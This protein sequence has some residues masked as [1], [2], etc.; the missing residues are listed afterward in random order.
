MTADIGII[1]S[2]LLYLLPSLRERRRYLLFEL[3]GEREIDK[4]EL[5][6]EIWNSIYSLYGDVGASESKLWLIKYHRLEDRKEE[7]STLIVG[8]LRCAHNKV[9]EVRAS[10]AC[11]HTV[12]DARVGIR[13][14]RTSGSIKGASRRR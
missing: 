13:V 10:L 11:I 5:M 1:M 12:N 8:V 6:K 3:M 9:E 7:E 2:V 4:R 14:I